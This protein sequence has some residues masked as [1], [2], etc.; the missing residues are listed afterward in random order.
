MKDQVL[1][2]LID[3]GVTVGCDINDA[4]KE[5]GFSSEYFGLILDQ[6]ENLGLIHQE[7]F[8]GGTMLITLTAA[9]FDFWSHGGFTA[10]EEL[11]Q[12]NIERLLL[13]IESLKPSMPD[14]VNTITA[15]AA[16]VATAL[17]LFLT[18]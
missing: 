15:I 14:K 18:K 7:K 4:P 2:S 17:G 1:K 6:F 13:E 5:Y 16:N 10:Q 3:F 8:L 11:L 12:K 9:A